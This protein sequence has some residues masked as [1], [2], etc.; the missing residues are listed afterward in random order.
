MSMVQRYAHLSPGHL[1]AAVEKIVPIPAVA[2]PGAVG[3]GFNL[4]AGSMGAKSDEVKDAVS[5]G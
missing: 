3:L 2:V 4:D 5:Y 1:A